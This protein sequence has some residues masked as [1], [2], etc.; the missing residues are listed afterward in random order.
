[1]WWVFPASKY[2]NLFFFF[3]FSFSLFDNVTTPFPNIP[4]SPRDLMR[5]VYL[6]HLL[7][8]GT[9][10]TD[11]NLPQITFLAVNRGLMVATTSVQSWPHGDLKRPGK[12]VRS[13][14]CTYIWQPFKVI[15]GT[16]TPLRSPFMQKTTGL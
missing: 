4:L 16:S 1:M 9:D 11:N 5:P 15:R 14:L 3:F 6:Q 7:H 2:A 8:L 10:Y 12:L 13:P